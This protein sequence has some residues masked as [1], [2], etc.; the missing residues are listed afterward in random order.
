M[1]KL[2]VIEGTDGSGKETQAKLLTKHLTKG[3]Y[4]VQKISFPNYGTP[5]AKLVEMY[6]SGDFEKHADDVNPYAASVLYTVDRFASFKL[7][8]EEFYNQGGILICDRYT[9]SNAVFQGTKIDADR[10]ESYLH[11]LYDLEYSKVGIPVPDLVLFLDVNVDVSYKLA[12]T[13]KDKPGVKHDIHEVD[14]DY[15]SRCHDAGINIAK[16]SG[17]AIINCTEGDQLR[18]I[19]DIHQEILYYTQPIIR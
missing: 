4:S 9:T 17:W 2:I 3:G 16:K 7:N 6:L 8:Y 14:K 18:S 12:S 19:E 1:G 11:W 10:R 13:R 15:L 5:Q